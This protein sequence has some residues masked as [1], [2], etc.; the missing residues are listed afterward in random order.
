[1]EIGVTETGGDGAN[2][3][4]A[5]SDLT[6]LH[7]VDNELAGHRFEQRSLHGRRP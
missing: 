6:G 4:I 3:H 2:Q 5:R 1:V 7:V